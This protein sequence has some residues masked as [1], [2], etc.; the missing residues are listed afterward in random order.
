MFFQR[1]VFLI[2]PDVI[3]LQKDTEEGTSRGRTF[4][5]TSKS[6]IR[7]RVTKTISQVREPFDVLGLLIL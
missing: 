7:Y 6:I 3:S 5:E 1:T 2:V 4:I